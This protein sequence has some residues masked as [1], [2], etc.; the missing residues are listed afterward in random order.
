MLE[1][2]IQTKNTIL[3]KYLTELEN[4]KKEK[5]AEID[6]YKLKNAS[7]LEKH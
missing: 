3:H 7:L 1:E 5:N 6:Q 2:T 4:L